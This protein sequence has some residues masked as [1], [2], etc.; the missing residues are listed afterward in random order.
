MDHIIRFSP[1]ITTPPE[2]TRKIFGPP[3]ISPWQASVAYQRLTGMIQNMMIASRG[4]GWEEED[5]QKKG[6]VRRF[7]HLKSFKDI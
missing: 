6:Q 3:D 1:T 7:V 5:D 2:P 4:R